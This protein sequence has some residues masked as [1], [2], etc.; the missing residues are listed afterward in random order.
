[1]LQMQSLYPE[2]LVT[3]MREELT[4]LGVKEL[5]T[6]EDVDN[7][8]ANH[9]GTTLVIINSVCGCAAGMARPAAAKAFQNEILPQKITT[10]FAGVDREATEQMRSYLM[11][12]PPSSPAMALFKDGEVVHF[13]PR[14][15]IEGNMA[16]AITADLTQAFNSYCS[17]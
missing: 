6:V 5:R 9:S 8:F 14:M 15:Q 2:N 13:I 4:S 17:K 11:G 16:E 3:P 10:V 1:M 7:E 12:Y